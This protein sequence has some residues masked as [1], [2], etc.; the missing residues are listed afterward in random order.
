[1]CGY[2]TSCMNIRFSYNSENSFLFLYKTNKGSGSLILG[3]LR[4]IGCLSSR[5][6]TS[7]MQHCVLKT[8]MKRGTQQTSETRPPNIGQ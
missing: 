1:M 2:L 5:T 8:L 3:K 7:S 4:M 6:L